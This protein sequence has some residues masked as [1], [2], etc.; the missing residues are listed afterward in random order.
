MPGPL[1]ALGDAEGR[2]PHLDGIARCTLRELLEQIAHRSRSRAAILHPALPRVH[3][4][5][6]VLDPD[7]AS[8]HSLSVSPPPALLL[9]PNRTGITR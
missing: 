8:R 2:H 4:R 9:A 3:C 6:S 1:H 7:P 5:T